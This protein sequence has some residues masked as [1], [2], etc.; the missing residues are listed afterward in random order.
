MGVEERKILYR[1]IKADYYFIKMNMEK[2]EENFYITR[3][4][5]KSEESEV[6]NHEYP[7]IS[8]EGIEKGLEKSE[9]IKKMIDK[10]PPKSIFWFGGA[11]EAIRTKSTI[12]LYGEG[13][14]DLYKDN[15]NVVIITKKEIDQIIKEG[16]D[17]KISNKITNIINS[18]ENQNKKIIID[19]PLFL[20]QFSFGKRWKI[21]MNLEKSSYFRYLA[22]K[23]GSDEEKMFKEWI[24]TKGKINDIQG[25]DPE[26]IAEEYMFGMKRLNKFA[27]KI[28]SN[29][30]INIGA[31]TH[32]W[33]LDAAILKLI[34][35]EVTTQVFEEISGGELTDPNEG[36]LITLYPNGDKKILFRGKEYEIK[37]E[38]K[39]EE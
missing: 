21:F 3:H 11:T 18:E 36:T 34:K 22:E 39:N 16:Q 12:R 35:G 9:E 13:L 10:L 30:P 29:R 19:Y 31:V 1:P 15:P 17:G 33:D 20:K 27:K 32:R 2:N 4:S 14:K 24:E 5:I 37:S 25:P 7:G 28:I 6:E 8:P 38:A 26:R 23:Y